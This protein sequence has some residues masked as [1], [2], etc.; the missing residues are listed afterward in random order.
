MQLR[1]ITEEEVYLVVEHGEVI[2]TYPQD[3]PYP[4][5]LV[6]G[7]IEQRPIHVRNGR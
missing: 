3:T 2:E 7:W 5:R 1:G 6:L 4:S